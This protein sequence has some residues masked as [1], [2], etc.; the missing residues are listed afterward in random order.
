MFLERK[1]SSRYFEKTRIF[2]SYCEFQNIPK[3]LQK[4]KD[5]ENILYKALISL[6]EEHKLEF[7]DTNL[8]EK[9]NNY[10]KEYC[11][12]LNSIIGDWNEGNTPG[13]DV[14]TSKNKGLSFT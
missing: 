14:R 13:V 5:D 2:R 11:K 9:Y 7:A 3:E 6:R 1:N 4:Q 10:C 12:K 8:K